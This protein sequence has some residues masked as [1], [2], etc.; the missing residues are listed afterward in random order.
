[1]KLDEVAQ[2]P[3]ANRNANIKDITAPYFK[4]MVIC[5]RSIANK[6]TDAT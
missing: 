4:A 2:I 5:L 3:S 6:M 1:M